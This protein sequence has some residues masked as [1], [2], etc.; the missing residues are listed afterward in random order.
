LSTS[1]IQSVLGNLVALTNNRDETALEYLLAQSLYDLIAPLKTKAE[2][3]EAVNTENAL[4]VIIYRAIDIRKSLFSSV[5]IGKKTQDKNYGDLLKQALVDCFKSGKYCAYEQEGEPHITLYPFKNAV[6]STV[7]VIAI[8]AQINDAQLHQIITMLLQIHQNFAGLINDNEH[9]A[10]TGLLNRK[11]FQSKMN[12]ILS[13]KIKIAKRKEDKLSQSHFLAIFDVDYFKNVNDDY[14]HLAGDNVLIHL[15]ELMRK[16]FRDEDMLFR[17]GG[18]EFVGVFACANATE[19]ND[20]IERFRKQVAKYDFPQVGKVTI[21][22]GFTKINPHDTTNHMIER[23]DTALY[24]AK[25]NGRNRSCQFERLVT[26]G[27]FQQSKKTT[28]TNYCAIPL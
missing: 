1:S 15:T 17:F 26:K 7:A 23:A 25:N 18:E 10:L 4:S 8:E 28:R 21:S 6:G 20:V 19:I 22:A 14:G 16:A 11:T 27:A 13:D 9:D 24:Y 2:D 12:K 3:G 5:V